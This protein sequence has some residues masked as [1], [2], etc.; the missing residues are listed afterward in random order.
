ARAERPPPPWLKLRPRV[1]AEA[2]ASLFLHEV[3]DAVAVLVHVALGA[4]HRVDALRPEREQR[5]QPAVRAELVLEVVADERT[6]EPLT[7]LAVRD[8]RT[9][10]QRLRVAQLEEGPDAPGHERV[11]QHTTT[12]C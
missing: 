12:E 11:R 9:H 10:L 7:R 8:R 5:M 1:P 6:G 4:P 3:D 2:V